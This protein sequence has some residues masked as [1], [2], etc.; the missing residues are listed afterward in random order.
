VSSVRS[1]SGFLFFIY[2]ADGLSW[3]EQLGSDSSKSME[4]VGAVVL[5]KTTNNFLETKKPAAMATNQCATHVQLSACTRVA[6][7][8]AAESLDSDSDDDDF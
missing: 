5:T 2:D 1:S 6:F 8:K 3:A 7:A 4:E